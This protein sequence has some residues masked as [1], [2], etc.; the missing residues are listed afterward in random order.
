MT[1]TEKINLIFEQTNENIALNFIDFCTDKWGKKDLL[2]YRDYADQL[3]KNGLVEFTD[4]S[5]TR[6][7]ITEKG[8]RLARTS[9][10]IEFF[11]HKQSLFQYDKMKEEIKAELDIANLKL[12][13]RQL[14]TFWITLFIAIASLAL[15]IIALIMT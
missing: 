12:A 8:E 6:I 2:L 10:F 7:C 9:S 1:E 14:K 4:D 11:N 15:S 5:E 13:R 3:I